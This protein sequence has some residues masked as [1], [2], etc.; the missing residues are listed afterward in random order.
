MATFVY[1]AYDQL[2]NKKAGKIAVPSEMDARREL[3]DHGLSAYFLEDIRAVRKALHKRKKRRKILAIAGVILIAAAMFMSGF[4]VRYS[5]RERDLSLEDY[6][7]AGAVTGG[8]GTLVAD[9]DQG[10]QFARQMYEAWHSFAPGVLTGIE[11]RKHFMTLYVARKVS[12]LPDEDLEY[13]AT[14]SV[15]ALQRQYDTA[16]ATLLIIQDDVPI[17]EIRYNGFTKSTKIT[18]YK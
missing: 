1:K 18:H 8:S 2:G 7:T 17:M 16:G 4:M 14:Q 11:V 3:R 12:R 6:Q 15:S 13:L 10:K 5:G 9:S